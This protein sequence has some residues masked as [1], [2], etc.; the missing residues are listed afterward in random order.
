VSGIFSYKD[1]I[2]QVISLLFV[3]GSVDG[4]CLGVANE[5]S[6]QCRLILKY[7]AKTLD[8]PVIV[9]FRLYPKT[10]RDVTDLEYRYLYCS[11]ADPNSTVT[12]SPFL[13]KLCVKLI[14]GKQPQ[15]LC[16]MSLLGPAFRAANSDLSCV[17][18]SVGD[19]QYAGA[20]PYPY[21]PRIS[22]S[23]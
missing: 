10:Y 7:C 15:T 6:G 12:G 2:T 14:L 9:N 18:C 17:C 1:T 8:K 3:S 13:F 16:I 19:P 23:D 20:D 4:T 21:N 11:S 22:T 5:F